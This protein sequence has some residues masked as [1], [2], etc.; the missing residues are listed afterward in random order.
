MKPIQLLT[1][2][3]IFDLKLPEA[4]VKEKRNQLCDLRF[5]KEANTSIF[6][7]SSVFPVT[8]A[9]APVSGTPY[10]EP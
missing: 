2:H 7:E 1:V 6:R 8:N 9:K 4:K 5:Q 3:L 10:T